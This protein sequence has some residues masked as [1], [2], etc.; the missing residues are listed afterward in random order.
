MVLKNFKLACLA[1]KPGSVT[2]NTSTY[3]RSDLLTHKAKLL[4]M[5]YFVTLNINANN[6]PTTRNLP[7]L[8][9]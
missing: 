1:Y 7:H 6:E 3:E 4:A 5:D 8:Y 9:K 2:Y